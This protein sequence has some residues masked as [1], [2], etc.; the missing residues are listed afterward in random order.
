MSSRTHL[1]RALTPPFL[2]HFAKRRLPWLVRALGGH[3]THIRFSGDYPDFETARG[4]CTG[5]D[6]KL[7][8]DRTREALLK[9]KRGENRWEQDG[10]VSDSDEIPWPLLAFL[11]R[12][13]AEK[14]NRDLRVLDFGGSLGTLYFWCRPYWPVEIPLT[15]HVV[16]QKAHVD[17]GRADFQD[18]QLF[19]NY[20]VDDA[21]QQ[22][23]PDV[24]ILSGVLHFLPEPEKFLRELLDRKIPNLVIDRTPLW[25]HDRHRLTIQEVP[26]E[27][28]PASYP[29]WFLSK[30]RILALIEPHYRLLQRA[31]STEAWE[32]DDNVVE[33]AQWQFVRR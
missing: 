28:Y 5:Y 26:P 27:I 6:H 14:K 20:S 24:L 11:L 30:S 25:E 23:V 32:I 2:W 7:I 10:M 17:V 16:E 22:G 3:Y 29:A 31:P 33:S 13:T 12:I 15:W 9:V 1:V 19:F 21:L 8:L 18:H 4:K